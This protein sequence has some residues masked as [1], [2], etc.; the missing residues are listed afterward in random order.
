MGTNDGGADVTT[1]TTTVLNGLLAAVNASTKIIVLRPYNGSSAATIQ[2]GI[3]ACSAPSR[4]T[5]VD[6]TGWFNTANASDS[7]HPYGAEN[8]FHIAPLLT[9]TL[10]SALAASTATTSRTL[11]LTL[12]TDSTTLAANLTG[13]QWTWQDTYN[14]AVLS[15][16]S[17]GTT[18][19]SG[20][21]TQSVQTTL[22]SGASGQ[23][24][25]LGAAGVHFNGAVVLS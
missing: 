10:R 11:T 5:Y 9:T 19:A 15:S 6:T 21:F 18:N 23:L 24:K 12:G 7:L 13:L 16:G 22:A 4:I 20:V 3:A 2:A 8:L 17:T 25:I 1:A 14:G